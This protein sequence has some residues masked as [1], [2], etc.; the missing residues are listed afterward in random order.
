MKKI[1]ITGASGLIGSSVVDL[2]K[3]NYELF[4]IS[5]KNE[6]KF[7]GNANTNFIQVDL[8]DDF[9][10]LLPKKID[11]IIHLA[12]SDNFRDF[13]NSAIEIFNVNTISTLK[14]I[15]Y[16]RKSQAKA[17]IYASS[18]AVYG[19][20]QKEHHEEDS[21]WS[22]Q[23]DL[24]FYSTSKLCSEAILQNYRK[25]LSVI[26][27]RFFFVYGPRQNKSMLI[28]RLIENVKTNTII[29]LQGLDG[30][31]INP[32]FVKD[33]AEKIVCALDSHQSQI[34]NIGGSEILTLRQIAET[35]GRIC[36]QKPNFEINSNVQPADLICSTERMSQFLGKTKYIF[37]DGVDLCIK[38]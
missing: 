10:C 14:L 1:L 26:C 21:I 9:E 29:S 5:R 25:F 28:P 30:I 27:L 15:E 7:L 34:L 13:P 33:A 8:T 11:A 2:L 24:G 6:N 23:C 22:S 31:K 32:I 38:K 12:Q 17:F 16:A 35:I 20:G 4:L 18:G 19:D 36:G 37:K 3:N